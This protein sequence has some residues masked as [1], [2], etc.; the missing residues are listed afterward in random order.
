MRGSPD[1]IADRPCRK[2]TIPAHLSDKRTARPGAISDNFR[3]ADNAG[4]GLLIHTSALIGSND[5]RF[6]RE[7]ADIAPVTS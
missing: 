6:S 2:A 1:P 4:I 7:G 5:Q 3:V